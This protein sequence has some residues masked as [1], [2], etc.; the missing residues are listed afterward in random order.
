MT[1]HGFGN[2]MSP[3]QLVSLGCLCNV[4]GAQEFFEGL[5]M[6]HKT[7]LAIQNQLKQMQGNSSRNTAS[8][9]R[10]THNPGT[11][12]LWNCGPACVSTD[13]VCLRP[14]LIKLWEP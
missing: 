2:H 9:G 8:L 11:L 10:A 1:S 13:I 3:I 14:L 6:V 4:S 5:A 7:V 12:C